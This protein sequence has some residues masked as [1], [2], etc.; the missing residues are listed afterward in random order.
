MHTHSLRW[1]AGAAL[2]LSAALLTGCSSGS[3]EAP[4][5][6]AAATGQEQPG[7]VQLVPPAEF[8]QAITNG[9]ELIDVRTPEE[10]AAG[11]I[12][13]AVNIDIASPDFAT[14]ISQLDPKKTYAVYCRSDNRSGVATTQ[15]ANSGFTSVF[16]LDGGI[17]AWEQDGYPVT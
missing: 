1:G 15:M 13:G 12:E 14:Q 4:T 17:I 10:F 7:G 11:H 8:Q 6:P 3:S 5:S 2:V 16:D 9:A